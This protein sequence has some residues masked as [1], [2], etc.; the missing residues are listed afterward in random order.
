MKYWYFD[1]WYGAKVASDNLREL[2]AKAKKEDGISVS[3]YYSSGVK[4]IV[5]ANGY[6]AP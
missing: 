4:C 2:K 5:N 1:N 6:T 3:I